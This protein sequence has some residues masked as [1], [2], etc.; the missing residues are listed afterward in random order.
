MPTSY[1]W[2]Y[3][4]DLPPYD[5]LMEVLEAFFASYP[6]G[7]Y[8]CE[9]RERFR[10]EFRRG[11]WRK[12]LLGLGQLVPDR[13]IKGQFNQWPI[14]VR[15]LARPSPTLYTVTVRYELHLPSSIGKLGPALQASV[16]LH[17]LAELD[18]LSRY[19][20]QCS[21]L[22]SPPTVNPL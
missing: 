21:G 1:T 16:N 13:L 4:I 11:L 19:L 5:K 12:N 8:T 7:D 9:R 15:V 14:L 17:A 3:Q 22:D 18:D 6:G 10:L 20:A 2:E